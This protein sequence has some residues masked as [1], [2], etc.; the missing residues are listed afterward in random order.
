MKKTKQKVPFIETRA[1]SWD[2]KG[3]ELKYMSTGR[4]ELFGHDYAISGY[5]SE[6]KEKALRSLMSE[7]SNFKNLATTISSMVAY[8]IDNEEKG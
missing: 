4:M 6:T 3:R 2:S 7:C 8:E 5:P 1:V